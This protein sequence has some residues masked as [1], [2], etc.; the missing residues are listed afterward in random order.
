[1]K[2]RLFPNP[3][4]AMLLLLLFSGCAENVSV[5]ECVEG[6]PYGFFGGLWHGL[7]AP[8]GLVIGFFD[9]EV[10]MFAANNNGNWYG[11]GFLLGSGG[12]GILASSS[13]KKKK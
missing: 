9:D 6:S 5:A 8:I 11:L 7:I 1:M 2:N 3:L 12:W 10:T 13:S 4:L